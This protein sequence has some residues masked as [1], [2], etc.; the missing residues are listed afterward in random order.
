MQKPNYYAIIPAEVRYSKKLTPNA[1]LLY[2]EI[3]A[4]SNKDN[5]CWASNKYF[6]N[7]YNVSTVTIS[8]WISSLVK[9]NFIIRKIIY[10]KGTKEI[11]KRYL[12]LCSEGINNIDKTPI[13]KIVKDNITSINTTSN[14][15]LIREQKFLDQ[16][17]LLDYDNSIKKSFT[18]YWTEPN[19]S[20]TKMKFEMQSTFDINR[21]LARWKKND[22]SWNKS[23]SM[24]KIHQHLQK[25]I[26]VKEKLKQQLKN[27][28]N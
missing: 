16:V 19:K 28:I 14:N 18:D 5:V 26:N 21:R 12:Q 11:D 15:I 10:I 17:S 27:E 8:R 22:K 25:N 3:T 1:K 2:A 7:L 9:N 6:S 4:L 24:S 20:N 23:Q 13:N